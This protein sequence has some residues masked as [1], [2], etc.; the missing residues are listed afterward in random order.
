MLKKANLCHLLLLASTLILTQASTVNRNALSLCYDKADDTLLQIPDSC[1]SYI[2]CLHENPITV[3]CSNGWGF[4]MQAKGCVQYSQSDCAKNPAQEKSI[5]PLNNWEI[6]QPFDDN[7]NIDWTVCTSL[8]N[9]ATL[10][11]PGNCQYYIYCLAHVPLQVP[12]LFNMG[13]ST[14]VEGCVKYD[15]SD[16][17]LT[18]TSTTAVDMTTTTTTT[19]TTKRMTTPIPF[20]ET[21]L[22]TC[23]NEKRPQNQQA[24]AGQAFGA[25]VPY[26]GDCSKFLVCNCEYPTVKQCAGGTWFDDTIKTCNYPQA[27]DCPWS[28]GSTTSEKP[29]TNTTTTDRPITTPTV[30][31]TD[32]PTTTQT[33]ITTL[34]PSSTTTDSGNEW[35]QNC[36]PPEGMKADICLNYNNGFLLRYPY[37]CNAY[38]NCTNGCPVMNYCMPDKVFNAML[39]I[40]DTPETAHCKELP[41]PTTTEPPPTTT[42]EEP[43]TTTEE[44][45]TTTEE[46]TTTTEEPT[47]TT[48]KPTTTTEE[49]TTTTEEPTTT[50]EKPTTTTEEPT[51][52][53]EEPTTTTEEPT[54]TTEEPTTTTEEP[55]TTTE[56]PT[57]TTEEPNTTTEEPTTTTKELTTTT[58]EPTTTPKICTYPAGIENNFC[59]NVPDGSL[60]PYPY[61]CTLFIECLGECPYLDSCGPNKAF[62][63]HLGICDEAYDI[64][65]KEIPFP[66]PGT[67]TPSTTTPVSTETEPQPTSTSTDH[68]FTTTLPPEVNPNMCAGQSDYTVYPYEGNCG[69]YLVC[70]NEKVELRQCPNGWLFNPELMMCDEAGEEVCYT[71]PGTT[72]TVVPSTP[73]IYESCMGQPKGTTFPDPQECT[74]YYY[75]LDDGHFYILR[76]PAN[77]FYDPYTGNCGPEVSP[78]AC[79]QPI[80]T[81]STTPAT[82]LS[83][84]EKCVNEELG[85]TF[86]YEK[87]CQQYI[88]CTANGGFVILNCPGNN[89]YYPDS[90]TCG[91]S[92][93]PYIC[94]GGTTTT[95]V[96]TTS[97]TQISTTTTKQTTT[98][99]SSPT[100]APPEN[101]ICGNYTNGELIEYPDNC[102][103][104]I[105]CVRPIP[106]GFFCPNNLYFDVEQ[107]A[108]VAQ[109]PHGGC[110]EMPSNG[111]TLAPPTNI[112]QGQEAGVSQ[113][114]PGDCQMYYECLGDGNYMLQVCIEGEYFDPLQGSCS[115]EVGVDYCKHDFDTTTPSTTTTSTT[116]RPVGG[117]CYQKPDGYKVP[118]PDDCIK[119][120]VC[121]TPIPTAYY[122]PSGLQFSTSAQEC[123][124]PIDSDCGV[125]ST[126][127]E[128]TSPSP[129]M[130]WNECT[131]LP[132][133]TLLPYEENC[134]MFIVCIKNLVHFAYCDTG[135]YFDVALGTCSKTAN[136]NS[137]I[138]DNSTTTTT[139]LPITTT[140]KSTTIT[141][142]IAT[143]TRDPNLGPC[144]GMPD[145]TKVPYPDNCN[146]YIVCQNPISVGYDCPAGTEFSAE[147]LECVAPELA[148]CSIKTTTEA[149]TT[150]TT[151]AT[152]P[153]EEDVCDNQPNGSTQTY[154]EDCTKYYMCVNGKSKLVSCMPNSYYNPLS[155]QCDS[156]SA[157]ECQESSAGL[158]YGEP[159]GYTYIYSHDC[160]KYYLCIDGSPYVTKCQPNTFY[161]P[162]LGECNAETSNTTC[163]QGSGSTTESWTTTTEDITAPSTESTTTENTTTERTTT[164]VPTTTESST[165]TTEVTT[166]TS[167]ESTTVITEP[168]TSTT[169]E[170]STT[171][172]TTAEAP[173]PSTTEPPSTM[174]TTEETSTSVEPTTT[175]PTTPPSG[176]IC[177]GQESGT[178]LPY[179]GDD[180]KYVIC[181]Y[182]VPEVAE[183]PADSLYNPTTQQCET[184]DGLVPMPSCSTLSYGQAMAYVGDCTKYYICF[185][186]EAQVATCGNGWYF[187]A[188]LGSCVP[189]Q[190]YDCP[191]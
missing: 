20:A 55:T 14:A 83:P 149:T 6:F 27:V 8:P 126:T 35:G 173:T 135:E 169:S 68:P 185:G 80:T 100:M 52:T 24:C 177:C 118:Y 161:N 37:N 39:K 114:Y 155:G 125:I 44:P 96:A 142:T 122:C 66:T 36:E 70:M 22:A 94:L 144:D 116:S 42:T 31:T 51:T 147:K 89:Y 73:G 120:I 181:L 152:T 17:V 90:G 109:P 75:C 172:S 108:C 166:S 110:S 48:E 158:C 156:T 54:T 141:T 15:E 7:S 33:P 9:G 26:P 190:L 168:P 2:H 134:A 160:S 71:G 165:T 137:C 64:D 104:Y 78:T 180:T 85:T 146:K 184:H 21:T 103:K 133:F 164:E 191:W 139:E 95:T 77:N 25:L 65:C 87:N 99:T 93:D 159:D 111:T 49:P 56:K 81:A 34:I 98:T 143:T 102:L 11:A 148:N 186:T 29:T 86:P 170:N 187:N 112:C 178:R 16:C 43:T 188:S 58:E 123:V 91:P 154:P 23:D 53:T 132:D 107:Q 12:C 97:T 67:P 74:S 136:S 32:I 145:G 82:T 115:S 60:L 129:T 150:T 167:T 40:C 79:Q 174:T 105:S 162:Q 182:P 113:T 18:A 101:G 92:S 163:Q 19:T 84:A 3:Y 45:T 38:I 128:Q 1:T 5:Q 69:E 88:M 10:P 140:T 151:E 59:E 46:P 176:N 153:K 121:A 50:T 119:Y 189:S 76:C 41:I 171:D 175:E 63:A 117:I 127:T 72:T 28:G 179:P 138:Y 183:C 13:Y 61:N 157:T 130:P 4:S 62:N 131:G 30:T 47:T 124:E 106:I 57:T